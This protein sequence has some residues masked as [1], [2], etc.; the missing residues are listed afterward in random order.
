MQLVNLGVV[1]NCSGTISGIAVAPTNPRASFTLGSGTR[2]PSTFYPGTCDAVFA[3]PFP[4]NLSPPIKDET[5][6]DVWNAALSY[7]FT[8]NLMVYATAGTSFRNGPGFV[9]GG[10]G[11]MCANAA[12]CLPYVTLTPETSLGYE[13]GFKSYLFDRRGYVELAVFEQTFDGFIVRGP[14]VPYRRQHHARSRATSFTYNADV[15]V[16][17]FDALFNFDITDAWDAGL[18]VSYADGKYDDALVPC[19]DSNFDGVPDCQPASGRQR[20][21]FL[22]VPGRPGMRPEVRP[23]LRCAPQTTLPPGRRP[24]MRACGR[25]LNSPC[26]PARPASSVACTRTMRRTTTREQDQNFV[27]DAYGVLNLYLGLRSDESE[28]GKSRLSPRTCWRTIRC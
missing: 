21:R 1:A 15:I 2:E 26:L 6:D 25:S 13:V 23:G 22:S 28:R 3:T 16:T 9:V 18:S 8:E 19:R 10:P 20:Q 14:F 17:G 27:V 24:G 12:Y 11:T 5:K 7:E 4:L